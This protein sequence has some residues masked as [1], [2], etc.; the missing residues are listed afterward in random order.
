MSQYR[1]Y[2]IDEP[3]PKSVGQKKR[4]S[5]IVYSVLVPSFIII[6]NLGI[7]IFHINYLFM[8][9]I[10]LPVVI[11]ACLLI[12]SKL[13]NDLKKIKTIG[14]IE[15]TKSSVKKRL[16]DVSFDY[17]LHQIEKIEL[18][19]HIPASTELNSVFFSYILKI[20][21]RDSHTESLIVSDKPVNNRQHLSLIDTL[22]TLKK[23]TATEITISN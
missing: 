6:L 13:N 18:A 2:K 7:M 1:I 11:G 14:D 16:G 4:R 3:D 10:L 5:A 17:S 19:G 8:I 9:C 23:F 12:S 15:F 20:T 21:F 22:N